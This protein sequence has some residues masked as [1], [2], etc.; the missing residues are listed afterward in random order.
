M[1]LRELNPANSEGQYAKRDSIGSNIPDGVR[2]AL[3]VLL[4]GV[5]CYV[6]NQIGFANKIPPH[7]ISA[8][9]P[10][11]AIL[12]AVLVAS[13]PRHWWLYI[14]A[15]YGSSVFEDARAGFPVP[16]RW[17]VAAGIIE[18]LVA[19]YGVRRF[20][21]GV[22][23]FDS[24]NNLVAYIAIAVVIAPLVGSFIAGEASA[25]GEYWSYWRVWLLSD[26]LAY[27][28]VAPVIL[29]WMNEGAFREAVFLVRGVEVALIVL[30][31][32][33]VWVTI[34]FWAP[35]SET[36]APTLVY[37]QLPFALWAAV[38]LGPPGSS[39]AILVITTL[40]IAGAAQGFGPFVASGAGSNVLALQAFL[41]VSSLP[42]MF[43]ATIVAERKQAEAE[44]ALQ[45]REV[46]H[47][48]RVSMLGGLSASIAHEINQPLG[49]IGRM[50]RR[51]FKCSRRNRPPFRLR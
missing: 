10:T 30:G 41:F 49:A 42:M 17:F 18:V 2:L 4:V 46:S 16:A 37:L 50:P 24:V 26:S 33:A 38:R 36:N 39:A 19:A 45:R 15:A 27:L 14:L 21:G 29:T 28:T 1:I 7:N 47:L 13:P 9:W 23:C 20:A 44:A 40:S 3:K 48:M 8:L 31:L 6:S 5:V 25:S 51:R 32:V 35:S 43:L 34:F 12:F 22:R 11:I